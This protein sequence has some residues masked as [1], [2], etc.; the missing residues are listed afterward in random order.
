MRETQFKTLDDM[1]PEGAFHHNLDEAVQ[2]RSINVSQPNHWGLAIGSTR[3]GKTASRQC[4]CS[5]FFIH[6][7]RVRRVKYAKNFT[8]FESVRLTPRCHDRL[9]L[10]GLNRSTMSCVVRSVPSKI[11]GRKA[12]PPKARA[13]VVCRDVVL[14]FPSLLFPMA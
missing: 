8:L 9:Q 14:T 5:I 11:G 2:L 7:L 12:K 3:A 13:N 4:G 6:R 10:E 1:D